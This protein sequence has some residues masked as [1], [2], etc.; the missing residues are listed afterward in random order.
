[1]PLPSLLVTLMEDD[2]SYNYVSNPRFFGLV[3][4]L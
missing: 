2:V 4:A 3:L 1:M